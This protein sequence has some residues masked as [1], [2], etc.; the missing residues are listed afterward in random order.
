L[1]TTTNAGSAEQTR[2]LA[3]ALAASLKPGDVIA[4]FG[5]LGSGKTTFIQGLAKGLGVDN[6]VTS[7]SFVIMNEYPLP[8][9]NNAGSFYHVDLYRLDSE[10]DVRDLGIED[11]LGGNNITAIEWAE[12]AP[13]LLPPFCKKI[14]FE[15]VSENER[16][17][18][19]E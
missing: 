4:L 13:H 8:A 18:T 5:Q 1:L 16:K 14:S 11:I 15:L 2:R 3:T 17:I 6:F 10:E 12:K 7:P 19:V 9:G